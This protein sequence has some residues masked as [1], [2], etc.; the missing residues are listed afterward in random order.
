MKQKLLFIKFPSPP[1]G[2]NY[3][4]QKKKKK[5]KNKKKKKKNLT[6]F[7]YSL[8]AEGFIGLIFC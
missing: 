8:A 5:K 2:N 1:I 3:I 6:P 7:S 4:Y